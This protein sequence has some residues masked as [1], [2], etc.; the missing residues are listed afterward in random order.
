MKVKYEDVIPSLIPNTI[1]QKCYRDNAN[2]VYYI[3]PRLGYMLHD[4]LMD[5]EKVDKDTTMPTGEIELGFRSSVAS[6]AANYDFFENPREFYVVPV[7][8]KN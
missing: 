8:N 4:K 5:F 3:T 1:M 6:C 7:F 2:F